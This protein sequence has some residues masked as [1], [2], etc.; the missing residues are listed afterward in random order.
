LT[1]K[2]KVKLQKEQVRVEDLASVPDRPLLDLSDAAVKAAQQA[3]LNRAR[4][5][6]A[7][8]EGRYTPAMEQAA[9]V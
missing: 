5:V 3:F 4:L 1:S 9:A 6:S 7:A 8:R 2:P